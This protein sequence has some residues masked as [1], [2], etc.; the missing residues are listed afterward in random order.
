MPELSSSPPSKESLGE[1][2]KPF[3]NTS[4]LSFKSASVQS[5]LCCESS[6]SE[7]KISPQTRQ[8][9][10]EDIPSCSSP[11][12]ESAPSSSL[13]AEPCKDRSKQIG[14]SVTYLELDC[15]IFYGYL[16]TSAT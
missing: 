15:D 14:S 8:S 7:R 2:G 13:P 5:C 3:S 12:G 9:G 6:C 1:S 16:E 11:A 4:P 10:G